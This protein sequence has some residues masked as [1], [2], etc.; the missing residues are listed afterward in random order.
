MYD[1]IKHNKICITGVS[2]VET[3]K[4]RRIFEEIMLEHLPN[5]MTD[6]NRDLKKSS[7][8]SK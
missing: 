8:N 6:I 7:R 4:E 5:L 2:E 1:A 3:G